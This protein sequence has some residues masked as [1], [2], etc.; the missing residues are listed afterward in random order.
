[1]ALTQSVWVLVF[2]ASTSVTVQPATVPTIPYA[3]PFPDIPKIEVFGGENFKRWQERMFIV[4]DM[5]GVAWV[6]SEPKTDA[7]AEAR[8]YGNKV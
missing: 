5:H 8:M 6:L 4:L 3:K 2:N 1:M 7:N